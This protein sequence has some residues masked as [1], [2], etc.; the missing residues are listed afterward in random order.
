MYQG[1]LV[2]QGVEIDYRRDADR[3]FG[4]VDQV[5]RFTQ[6]G[7]VADGAVGSGLHEFFFIGDYPRYGLRGWD[8]RPT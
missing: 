4:L 3:L 2:V 1:P 7:G 6:T 8:P 5:A